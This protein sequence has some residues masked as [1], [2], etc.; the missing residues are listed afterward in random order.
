M[1]NK[2]SELSKPVA[3]D[4]PGS[5]EES[6]QLGYDF[7]LD[8]EQ[9]VNCSALYSQEYVSALRADAA[10]WFEAFQKAVSIGAR[11]EERIAE[12]E[13]DLKCVI[14]NS[15]DCEKTIT[16]KDAA[17]DTF[18]TEYDDAQKIIA[19]LEAKL[20]TPVDINLPERRGDSYDWD[21]AS[22]SEAFNTCRSICGLMFR[23][24][25]RAAGFTV[26]GD[27]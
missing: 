19:E 14:A 15:V 17:I 26:E 24:Q 23:Q 7:E 21:G 1:D 12:L 9:K 18:I 8:D 27:E 5:K 6:R 13:Y 2:L 3:W 25:L 11:H 16:R 10:K 20:A 22:P 4:F